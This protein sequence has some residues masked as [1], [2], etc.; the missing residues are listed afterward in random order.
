MDI[1]SLKGKTQAEQL[2]VAE[3]YAGVA[4]GVLANIWKTESAEGTHPTM[5]GPATK[6][7][8]AK[9]HFQILDYVNE[10]LEKKLGR[11]IDRFDFTDS[12]AAAAELL[13]ENKSR[14]GTDEDAVA[15]YHG[16]TDKK[17]WGEA[18]KAYVSKVL[19]Q[20]PQAPARETVQVGRRDVPTFPQF[21]YGDN[22]PAPVSGADVDAIAASFTYQ[23]SVPVAPVDSNA[24]S[25]AGATASQARLEA[26]ETRRQG[27][28]F[29]GLYDRETFLGAAYSRT[30]TPLFGL[31]RDA[32]GPADPVDTAYLRKLADNPSE[33]LQLV[34]KPTPEE[35]QALL[36]T[37]SQDDLVGTLAH[38]NENRANDYVLAD[39]GTGTGMAAMA[40]AG[41]LDPTTYATGFAATK[42][43]AVA[44]YGAQALAQQGKQGAALAS[45]VAENAAANVAYEA[46][47]QA[48][49]EHRSAADYGVAAVTGL[50]PAAIQAPGIVRE[51]HQAL[52]DRLMRESI[53]AQLKAA[54][55]AV[56]ELG[57]ADPASISSR[58]V[59]DEAAHLQGELNARRSPPP[60]DEQLITA[61]EAEE[62]PEQP[63][64]Q[65]ATLDYDPAPT[66][67]SPV[68]TKL[69][70]NGILAELRTADDL[71]KA[72]PYHAKYGDPVPDDAKAVYIP[73]EDKVYIFRD[74]LT[75]E[76]A[77]NPQGLIAHEVGVHYGLERA[78]GTETLQKIIADLTA[79]ADTAVT[80]AR[81]MVPSDTP[82]HLRGEEM[83]GYLAET[84]PKSS[85]IQGIVSAVR[86][87]LRTNVSMFKGLTVTRADALAY[88][89]GAVKAAQEGRMSQNLTFPYVWHG[90]P[91]RNIDQLDTA[92]IG[93]GEGNAAFG[94]GNYVTSERG[95]A[96]DYRNK[97]SARRGQAP[98]E[99]GLYRV[100]INAK[101]E[102]LL[103]WDAPVPDGMSAKFPHLPRTSG[104]EFYEALAEELGS[105]RAASEALAAQ[106]IP[107]L[108]YA[109]GRTRNADVKNS[110]YV[111]FTNEGT[112]I[113]ARY[114]R[115]QPA[116]GP[117]A[118]GADWGNDPIVK[119]YGLDTLPLGS[120]EER[121]EAKLIRDIIAKAEDWV[122]KNPQDPE[123]LKTIMANSLFNISL[124]GSVLAQSDHPVAKMLSGIMVETPAGASGRNVTAAIRKAQYEREYV[125]NAIVKFDAAYT[126]YRNA[127]AGKV[128]GFI[129]DVMAG[130]IRE[131][132]NRLV[133]VE[134][135]SR[136][137]RRPLTGNPL[138]K[139][140]A[141]ALEVSYERM[142]LAQIENKTVGWGA[143]PTTSV[144]YMQHKTDAAKFLTLGPSELR[145]FRDV[146]RAQL[147]DVQ[148]M[149]KDFADKVAGMYLDH[150][151]VNANGGHE[152]PAN[153]HDPAAAHYFEQ[154]MKAAGMTRE[155]IQAFADKL[156]AGGASHTKK[157]L[158][159]DLIAEH[160]REDGSTFTLMDLFVTDHVSL[161]RNHARRVSGEVALAQQGILG[162]PGLRVLERALMMYPDGADPA[163][164]VRTQEAF[165]QVAAE[166]L[167]RPYGDQT[168]EWLNGIITANSTAN[169]GGMGF[170]QLGEYINVATGVG[171]SG[172]LRAV[173]AAPR[174]FAEVRAL[175]R[176]ETV[177][178]P[179]LT[180]MEIPGGGGEFGLQGYKLVTA[181]DNPTA[182]YDSVGRSSIG[183]VTK[184]ARMAGHALGAVS[185]QRIVHAVQVRG[186]AEQITHKAIKF[187]RDGAESVA[188][189]DMGFTPELQAKIKAELPRI[190]EFDAAGNLKSLDMTKAQDVESARAFISAVHRGAGQL[191]QESFVGEIHK[192]QHSNL[193]K[194]LTQFRTYPITAMEK[195]W[196]RQRSNYGPMA[197]VAMVVAAS[198]FAVP[199]HLSR[200]ALNAKGRPDE[201]EYIE[202]H[203]SP[204]ALAR[205]TMNYVAMMGMVPDVMDLLSA[206]M[207]G[208][209]SE[210]LGGEG[211]RRTP[212][213]SSTVPIVGY[214][215]N[216]MRGVLDPADNPHLLARALPFSNTPWLT[217]LVNS[218]RPES[219]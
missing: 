112:D 80:K 103:D 79:S 41:F 109:T 36:G 185:L 1:Q 218:L 24:V 141:D 6:W 68:A 78:V 107:G 17:N 129:D 169:L 121:S 163:Q 110:N 167:G 99:G 29:F 21:F 118:M 22:T 119:K 37:T 108:K 88:I 140:A 125:G 94:W 72:S 149:D 47:L 85:L 101:Q 175:A 171:I 180:S 43:F 205:A 189:Q 143:L 211:T 95:T 11:K 26:D 4:P 142:R 52:T 44:G 113:A 27:R 86:N 117:S 148:G 32:T 96:I 100:R 186:A 130:S 164:R 219:D 134:I 49:G 204:L 89:K 102:D 16:G 194:L 35:A 7:G 66:V 65:A 70:E 147:E 5:I 105:Q 158:K 13:K 208:A 157:R 25:T 114:S 131:E 83:L 33:V 57:D 172:T 20:T 48:L 46:T 91:T 202:K 133:A 160:K 73:Q 200:V 34:N 195:Q 97:E 144:G 9:G 12:L 137:H 31:V 162:S 59:K 104:R 132:F 184:L 198:A 28:D 10:S 50:L 153:I 93:T 39:A 76:E 192:W 56:A 19:G 3:E 92:Y 151:R 51:A 139:Q 193:G 120:V 42:A 55:R 128:R 178:N 201:D 145:A 181:F 2:R 8:T 53:D 213:L 77:A 156:S 45:L 60:T 214:A 74:R 215:D 146:L 87:W 207:P 187:I 188:L 123:R 116:N 90:G 165:Q 179:I 64:A 69:Y 209:W 191:I 161:L 135:E 217:P 174:L 122:S 183:P 14:Y 75:P 61:R 63:A 40:L 199:I 190:A 166:M 18:T 152:I 30:M 197:A 15:A 150:A 71:A 154:A 155:Q 126:Q 136:L 216:L 84:A 206:P 177:K 38:I 127:K 196:A 210:A 106:G 81:N 54:A 82:S 176:G 23:P 58:L 98:S 62:A 170:T 115:A 212:T 173:G 168:P 203:T 124:P 138:V 67:D 111:M 182:V 159:L